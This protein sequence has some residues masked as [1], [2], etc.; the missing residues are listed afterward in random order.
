MLGD[1]KGFQRYFL[2]PLVSLRGFEQSEYLALCLGFCVG[3]CVKRSLLVFSYY[4]VSCS[5]GS[6]FG[7][8][9]SS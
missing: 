3:L 9:E 7:I 1:P 2:F 4:I 8:V 5:F 6:I